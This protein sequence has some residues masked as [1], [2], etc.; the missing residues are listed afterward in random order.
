MYEQ[1]EEYVD[2]ESYETRPQQ[3]SKSDREEKQPE[4]RKKIAADSVVTLQELISREW[5]IGE[6]DA[7][8]A[9]G[10]LQHLGGKA[11][12]ITKRELY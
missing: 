4:P 2:A 10:V 6:V 5:S 12:Y 1:I 8:V 11:A 9:E 3:K 7:A